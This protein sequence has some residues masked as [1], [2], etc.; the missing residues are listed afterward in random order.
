MRIYNFVLAMCLSIFTFCETIGQ[1]IWTVKDPNGVDVIIDKDS[2]F[3]TIYNGYLLFYTVNSTSGNRNILMANGDTS[4]WVLNEDAPLSSDFTSFIFR[5]NDEL[6]FRVG[7]V[8]YSSYG[9]AETTE[10][11]YDNDDNNNEYNYLKIFE[12]HTPSDFNH[13]LLIEALDKSTGDTLILYHNYLNNTTTPY[14]DRLRVFQGDIMEVG[15][16][17]G[18]FFVTSVFD[19]TAAEWGDVGFYRQNGSGFK[20][21]CPLI[22]KQM[23][24][25]QNLFYS[26]KEWIVDYLDNN[27]K[28]VYQ[29]TQSIDSCLDVTNIEFP[30]YTVLEVL[31]PKK[32]YWGPAFPNEPA[33]SYQ[34]IV[35]RGKNSNGSIRYFLRSLFGQEYEIT[36]IRNDNNVDFIFSHFQDDS[37]YYYNPTETQRGLV[38][39]N[40]K[41]GMSVKESTSI[42]FDT[43]Y[44]LQAYNGKMYFGRYN[45]QDGAIQA[46][47]KDFVNGNK[48]EFLESTSGGR[49]ESP[50]NF[51]F[52]GDRIFV[53]S[54]TSEGIK[55]VVFDPDGTVSVNPLDDH[56]SRILVSPNPSSGIFHVKLSEAI[57][58]IPVLTYIVFDEK[59]SQLKDGKVVGHDFDVDLTGLPPGLYHLSIF[60][61]NSII[62]TIPIILTG[63]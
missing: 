22:E 18:E 21:L 13:D 50:I 57:S 61:K 52:M 7:D 11:F 59:G 6:I 33:L 53:H 45:S 20:L 51:S 23:Y 35:W 26:G 14:D 46:M 32:P 56:Y 28:V 4:F 30:N 27:E 58:N 9:G 17:T 38:R 42:P 48:Y 29:Y 39:T 63:Q 15:P 10:V 5:R 19:S 44:T 54:K 37:I 16:Y 43:D 3:L 2:S 34:D 62:N 40:F 60:D 49:I 24:Q 12:L 1:A 41:N 47:S 55:L 8:W 36:D 25:V 31:N